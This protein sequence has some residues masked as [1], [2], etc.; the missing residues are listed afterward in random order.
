[1]TIIPHFLLRFTRSTHALPSY[2]YAIAPG[3]PKLPQ[4]PLQAERSSEENRI[5]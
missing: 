1:M 2:T 5:F 3:T 4:S